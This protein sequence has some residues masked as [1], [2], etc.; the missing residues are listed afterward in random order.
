VMP[1]RTLETVRNLDIAP[2][3][4]EWLGVALPNVEGRS[5]ASELAP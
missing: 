2:T 3:I 5:L 4:A 1:G